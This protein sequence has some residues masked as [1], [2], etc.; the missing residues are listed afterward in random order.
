MPNGSPP[1]MVACDRGHR[2]NAR[3]QTTMQLV[4]LACTGGDFSAVQQGNRMTTI[5]I[6][7]LV[8]VLVIIGVL[9]F[10]DS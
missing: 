1:D 9:E 3:A 4:Q 7:A 2:L 10:R 8:L 5:W 6:L